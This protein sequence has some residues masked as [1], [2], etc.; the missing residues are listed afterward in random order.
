[1]IDRCERLLIT[2]LNVFEADD[3][4]TMLLQQF[5]PEILVPLALPILEAEPLSTPIFYLDD[6]LVAVLCQTDDFWKVSPSLLSQ[7]KAIVDTINVDE[8]A[9]DWVHQ[10]I[11]D[12][13]MRTGMHS[14]LRPGNH[15]Q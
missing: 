9:S 11:L 10:A 4:T 6:L 7:V 12:F 3:L 13:I 15:G 2:P 1:L 5:Y 8:V 14:H